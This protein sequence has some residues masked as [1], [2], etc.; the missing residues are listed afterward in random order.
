MEKLIGIS[1][2]FEISFDG[3]VMEK[4]S[5]NIKECS[6]NLEIINELKEKVLTS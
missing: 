6:T 4:E 1:E 5:S 3:L 2:L